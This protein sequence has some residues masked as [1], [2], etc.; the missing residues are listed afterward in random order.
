MPKPKSPL[1]IIA[2]V[3]MMVFGAAVVMLVWPSTLPSAQLARITFP[4]GTMIT[5]DVA[6]TAASRARGLSGRPSLEVDHGMLFIFEEPTVPTFWM[7]DMYFPIDIVWLDGETVVSVSADVQPEEGT[8]TERY[9]PTKPITRVLEVNAGLA[10]AHGLT[11]GSS[12]D[13]Q[14]LNE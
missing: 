4:D 13:I 1:A 7:P 8:P 3:L 10:K 6:D 9:S 14:L 11:A 5:A 12:L 2:S